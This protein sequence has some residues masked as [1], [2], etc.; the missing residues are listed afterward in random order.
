MKITRLQPL[1]IH[2]LLLLQFKYP[3]LSNLSENRRAKCGYVKKSHQCVNV[4]TNSDTDQN[5]TTI[6]V[7][8]CPRNCTH[9]LAANDLAEASIVGPTFLSRFILIRFCLVVT[10]RNCTCNENFKNQNLK[11][12]V[13]TS[14]NV[15]IKLTKKNKRLINK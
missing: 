2:L 1:G 9:P 4:R 15:N 14:R 5:V 6:L 8:I 10:H 3:R 13:G 7:R 12:E 11:Y